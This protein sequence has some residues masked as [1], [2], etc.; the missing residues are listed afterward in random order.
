MYEP[1]QNLRM[2]EWQGGRYHDADDCACEGGKQDYKHSAGA[3]TSRLRE[4]NEG[5][6]S[7]IRDS[8]FAAVELGGGGALYL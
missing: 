5:A 3:G 7:S 8:A 6:D 2:R 1:R 4:G